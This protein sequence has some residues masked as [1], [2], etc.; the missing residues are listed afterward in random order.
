LK[1][2]RPAKSNSAAKAA[3]LRQ[4]AALA[5]VSAM[6][7]SNFMNGR[8][9][10]MSEETRARIAQTVA[11]LNYRPHSAGRGLRTAAGLLIGMILV[12]ESPTFLTDPFI[13]QVVSGLSNCLSQHGYGLVLQGLPIRDFRASPLIRDQRTDAFCV[14]LSG[15]TAQRHEVLSILA[16]LHC[17][18]VLFQERPPRDARDICA[19]RQD[20]LGGGRILARHLVELGARRIL[21]LTPE[22]TWPAI[23]DR[24]KGISNELAVIGDHAALEVLS[25]GDG[26]F[27]AAE[28]ILDVH[29]EANGFPDAIMGGNDQ[30]GIAGLKVATAHGLKIPQDLLVTGFNAFEF[31]RYSDPVLT[32]A[33]SPAYEIGARGGEEIIARL[34][35]GSFREREIVYPVELIVGPSTVAKKN[36]PQLLRPFT[37]LRSLPYRR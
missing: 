19:I 6:T 34:K 5:K 8:F 12:D 30:L 18:I 9:Q 10:A 37:Q 17:P 11:E 35:E 29:L 20:D 24:V 15:R 4:V 13:T 23:T 7:V 2:P 27:T 33:H 28:T 22:L 14:M 36:D 32:S 16:A 26:S 1:K 3:T 25:C 31:W 21:F